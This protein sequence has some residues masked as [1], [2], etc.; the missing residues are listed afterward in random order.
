MTV[1]LQELGLTADDLEIEQEMLE[2]LERVVALEEAIAAHGLPAIETGHRI[3]GTDACHFTAP[4]SLPDD[5]A[6][7]SGRLLL[8]SSRAAFAGGSASRTVPWHAIAEVTHQDRDILLVR[9]DRSAAY[10]FRCNSYGDALCA[11]SI[12][13][14]LAV[15][16]P[17][18]P[19]V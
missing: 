15:R 19:R 8:T 13:R 18:A 5:P 2:A 6:Q 4:A 9:H 1:S 17:R 3:A 7:P 14:R 12:A 11:A 10:R 16:G